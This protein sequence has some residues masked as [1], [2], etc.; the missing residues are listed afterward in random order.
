LC[1]CIL[2][3]NGLIQW[4]ADDDVGMGWAHNVIRNWEQ[5]GFMALHGQLVDNP[6]GHG[7][8]EH[9]HVYPGMRAASLYPAFFIGRLFAWT[10]FH[11]L[12][13]HVLLSLAVL[14]STWQLLGRTDRALFIGGVVILCPGYFMWP[15]GMD[16]NDLSILTGFPYVALVWW[17]L[18]RP[19]LL[20]SDI[21]FLVALTVAYTVLNWSTALAHGLIFITFAVS[22][23]LPLRRLI[24]YTAAGAIAAGLVVF[25]GVAS[26][27]GGPGHAAA[28]HALAQ[29]LGAYGWGSGGYSDGSDTVTL[30]K[31]LA[32]INALGLF[33]FWIVWLWNWLPRVKTDAGRAL[34]SLA[35]LLL[36]AFD[37]VVMRNYFCHHPWMAG[38]LLLL[39]GV[40]SLMILGQAPSPAPVTP[41]TAPPA[42]WRWSW[43]AGAAA[44]F[45]FGVAVMLADR[46]NSAQQDSL[47]FLI[48]SATARGDEILVVNSRDPQLAAM[49]QRLPEVFDRSV[50]VLDKL[51]AP[52]ASSSGAMLLSA[53][54]L[55]GSWKLAGSNAGP[56]QSIA[57]VDDALAWFRQH[58]SHRKPGDRLEMAESYYLYSA[59]L[60][61]QT[62][63][64][65]SGSPMHPE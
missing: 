52:Q 57:L 4:L 61:S 43:T 20:A 35:P 60:P 22:G 18:R 6:G 37:A 15:T 8:L 29:L 23:M 30:F 36:A 5:T 19:R 33:P 16:P 25:V 11:V 13:Y 38:P 17:R 2:A 51:P 39:G 54:P 41:A 28:P 42:N 3:A 34:R 40:L 12:P 50:V 26:K 44:V 55:E 10:G 63:A 45:G 9:P 1:A 24:F 31:R 53:L 59:A 27:M 32:F 48:R 21:V 58:I 64:P 47:T 7:V 65:A 49:A 62:D 14:I 46:S 56:H